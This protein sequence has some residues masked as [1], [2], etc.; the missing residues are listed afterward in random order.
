MRESSL[1]PG[2]YNFCMSTLTP[3][4]HEMSILWFAIANWMR[5]FQI[6]SNNQ[7][8]LW[9]WKCI[10]EG[11]IPYIHLRI[12]DAYLLW[13]YQAPSDNI[14]P[15]QPLKDLPRTLDIALLLSTPNRDV[16][17]FFCLPGQTCFWKWCWYSVSSI[18]KSAAQ[19]HG[20]TIS[21]PT[22]L[23]W[24]FSF[25]SILETLHTLACI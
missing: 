22:S 25:T 4:K 17:H 15:V 6:Q 23:F 2:S 11:H 14:L 12:C 3:L 7:N 9:S 18:C 16:G 13:K 19:Q 10:Q 20:V 8:C 1:W 24:L 21:I 5:Q